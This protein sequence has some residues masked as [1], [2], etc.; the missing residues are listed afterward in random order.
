MNNLIM[1]WGGSE[2]SDVNISANTKRQDAGR[3]WAAYQGGCR[4]PQGIPDAIFEN[5]QSQAPAAQNR[6]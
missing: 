3:G 6:M 5:I 2:R 4:C 1:F